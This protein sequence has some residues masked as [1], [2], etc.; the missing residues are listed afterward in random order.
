MNVVPLFAPAATTRSPS[1]IQVSISSSFHA[2]SMKYMGI[3]CPVVTQRMT[4][5]GKGRLKNRWGANLPIDPIKTARPTTAIPMVLIIIVARGCW[6]REG[7]V[8][9]CCLPMDRG[10]S[11]SSCSPLLS[12]YWV[13]KFA[14]NC[15]SV[16]VSGLRTQECPM[17]PKY[18][19]TD[20]TII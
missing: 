1:F 7:V 19:T 4:L 18:N 12:Y 17:V 8:R 13:R 9:P 10:G 16:S 5:S 15:L 20:N 3:P 14:I 11:S 6:S 2:S